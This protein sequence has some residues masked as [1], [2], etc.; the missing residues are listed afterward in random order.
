MKSGLEIAQEAAL[1][2]IVEVAAAA[3]IEADE[4]EPFGRY[5]GKVSPSVLDRL[6]DR[7]DGKLIVTT[8]ITPTKAGEGK[9]TTA[10]SLAQ[11]LGK[12]GKNVAMCLREPSMGPVFGIKGG[13]TGGGYAQVVPMED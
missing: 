9:T 4:L 10:I 13:G 6:K 8:A 3:G 1:R 11:G 7:P 12:L 2:P 5:R